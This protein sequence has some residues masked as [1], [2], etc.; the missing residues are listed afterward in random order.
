MTNDHNEQFVAWCRGER[1]DWVK[2]ATVDTEAEA[3]AALAKQAPGANGRVL[4]AGLSPKSQGRAKAK[5][6]R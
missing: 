3:G 2:V 4:P 1:G 6:R 5:G